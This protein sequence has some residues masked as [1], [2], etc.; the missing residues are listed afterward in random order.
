MAAD[1]EVD[2]VAGRHGDVTLASLRRRLRGVSGSQAS[3]YSSLQE[4]PGLSLTKT[5]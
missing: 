2:D 1:V 5:R 4:D 3:G